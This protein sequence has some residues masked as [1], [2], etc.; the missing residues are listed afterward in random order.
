MRSHRGSLPDQLAEQEAKEDRDSCSYKEAGV[1]TLFLE[2][3][4]TLQGLRV[5]SLDSTTLRGLHT[6]SKSQLIKIELA[7]NNSGLHCTHQHHVE[8]HTPLMV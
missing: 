1:P 8:T 6:N 3:D 2:A 7:S 4:K 5:E